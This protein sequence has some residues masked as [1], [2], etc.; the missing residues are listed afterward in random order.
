M[1]EQQPLEEEKNIILYH[2]LVKTQDRH[3]I[4]DSFVQM[5]EWQDYE[6][7]KKEKKK[8]KAC[9]YHKLWCQNIEPLYHNKEDKSI[10]LR[11]QNNSV[12]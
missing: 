3:Y 1:K 2:L 6:N 4:N 8:K 9:S 7:L 5:V 10:K 11:F 12:S